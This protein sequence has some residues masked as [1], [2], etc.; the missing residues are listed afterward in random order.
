MLASQGH[1]GIEADQAEAPGNMQDQVAHGLAHFG[2][3]EI[4]LR[5]IVPRHVCAVVAVIDVTA[6]S[7]AMLDEFID[8]GGIAVVPVAVFDVDAEPLSIT[9]VRA[10][11]RV[12]R[13]GWQ[14]NLQEP[15]GVLPDPL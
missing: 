8:H 4:Q 9:K 5:R 11:E 15:L 10:A 6:P 1:G 13:I 3:Q 14:V 12:P 2:Q 7:T